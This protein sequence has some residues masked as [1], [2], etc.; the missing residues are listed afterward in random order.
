MTTVVDPRLESLYEQTSSVDRSRVMVSVLFRWDGSLTDLTALGLQLESTTGGYITARMPLS[1]LPALRE[2]GIEC[3]ELSKRGHPMLDVSR[4]NILADQI[5]PLLNSRPGDGVIIGVVDSG[6]DYSH[7]AFLDAQGRSRLLYIWDQRLPLRNSRGKQFVRGEAFPRGFAPR[8]QFGVEYDK[9]AIDAALASKRRLRTNEIWEGHGSHVAGIAAGN[10]GALQ[11]QPVGT[12]TGVATHAEMI[13]V[14]VGMRTIWDFSKIR[15]GVEYIFERAR[16]LNR[17]CIVNLSLGLPHGARDGKTNEEK[18]LDTFVEDAGRAIVIATGN[19]ADWGLHVQGRVTAGNTFP[20]TL[21][22]AT[23]ES[24]RQLVTEIWYGLERDTERF[25]IEVEAP[26]GQKIKLVAPAKARQESKGNSRLPSG[27]DIRIW[28]ATAHVPTGKNRILVEINAKSAKKQLIDR[29]NWKFRLNGRTVGT[30]PGDGIFH[31]YLEQEIQYSPSRFTSSVSVDSTVT[32][33]A[34]AEKV[35]SV[36]SYV[37]KPLSTPVKISSFSGRGPTVDGRNVPTI[38]APGE[39]IWS[40]NATNVVPAPKQGSPNTGYAGKAGTSMATPHVS[41]TVAAMLQ[42]KPGLDIATIKSVLVKS[43]QFPAPANLRNTWGAGPI[44]S[45]KAVN[46]LRALTKLS[47]SYLVR[48]PCHA[49]EQSAGGASK[50]LRG[51]WQS[52]LFAEIDLA[53]IGPASL[54]QLTRRWARAYEFG[55]ADARPMPG[56]PSWYRDLRGG[57]PAV[58]DAELAVADGNLLAS[59]SVPAGASHGVRL[60][61]AGAN[62]LLPAAESI[63]SEI[64]VGFRTQTGQLQYRIEGKHDGFP[65]HQVKIDARLVYDFDCLASGKSPA[66]LAAPAEVKLPVAGWAN[67]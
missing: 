46:N 21:N 30:N 39:R 23:N 26:G 45:L 27:T 20:F 64:T 62:P 7:P 10:G 1:A 41:G 38:T 47:V 18:S 31:G 56:K 25:D 11:G 22:V 35:I 17:P 55:A 52:V 15:S 16:E 5:P 42:T 32:F 36:G 40:V 63:D 49:F 13:V 51:G 61:V 34:T 67:L 37:T 57:A 48:V 53:M 54:K 66:D 4:G 19:Y 24:S 44:D 33:P 65:D 12:Y 9:P 60:L 8:F 43:V 2:L 3:I 58:G 28:S 6:V 50:W 59:W 14:A 29:G